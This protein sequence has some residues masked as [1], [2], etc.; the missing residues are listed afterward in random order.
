MSINLTEQQNY[1]IIG[2][3][4]S[5]KTCLGWSF[6]KNTLDA[7]KRKVY[8]F[9]YPRP[10]L[11]KS[12]PFEVENIVHLNR[13]FNITDGVVLIDESHK[14]FNVL[15]KKVNEELK[16]LLSVS[17][18]N[19]TCFIFICHNSYFITRGLFSFIDVKII[20]EVNQGHWE[21]ERKHMQ[22]LYEN[23]RIFG[24]EN[25]F[26]D[27]DDGRGDETFEK[28]EWFTEEMSMAYRSQSKKQ[29]FFEK[30]RKGEK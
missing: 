28:P 8:V 18:Q 20:K 22:K 26:I 16:N 6:A 14:L 25:F 19:N 11:L 12:L 4:G 3:K 29:D 10:E 13:L 2:K 27:C 21:L 5:A 1:L 9:D 15:N 7:S 30:I 24:K 17:R 23:V